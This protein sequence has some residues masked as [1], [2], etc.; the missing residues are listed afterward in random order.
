[1]LYGKGRVIRMT[2]VLAILFIMAIVFACVCEHLSDKLD[3]ANARIAILENRANC[4]EQSEKTLR[5][6]VDLKTK[7]IR[8]LN[9]IVKKSVENKE[10]TEPDTKALLAVWVV[11][12]PE[13]SKEQPRRI[14]IFNT[15]KIINSLQCK[16]I[17]P[18]YSCQQSVLHPWT[19][20]DLYQVLGPYGIREGRMNK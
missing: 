7:C 11:E 19:Q 13:L 12:E 4:C 20:A 8:G 15:Q 6:S 2:F 5:E 18:L 3:D 1:M 9:N 10:A 17:T 14:D 16:N